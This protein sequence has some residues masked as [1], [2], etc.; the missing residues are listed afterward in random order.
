MPHEQEPLGEMSLALEQAFG[1]HQA[2]TQGRQGLS[3]R[4]RC[5]RRTDRQDSYTRD[6][7]IALGGRRLVFSLKWDKT[8]MTEGKIVAAFSDT[9]FDVTSDL[10]FKLQKRLRV[11][12]LRMMFT[13]WVLLSCR[14]TSHFG[15]STQALANEDRSDILV[16]VG[17]VIPPTDY[18]DCQLVQQPF[19][20]REL[21]L[22]MRHTIYLNNWRRNLPKR[23]R[24]DEYKWSP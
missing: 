16:V 6:S 8:V 2:S 20:D 19:L 21:S 1:R 14:R 24:L 15:S 4:T 5:T 10:C 23:L 9:G 7:F 17:G 3:F 11:R 13:L 12:L 22:W 18:D